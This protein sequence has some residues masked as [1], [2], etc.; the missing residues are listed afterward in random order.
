M[1]KIPPGNRSGGPGNVHWGPGNIT[2]ISINAE[3]PNIQLQI[4]LNPLNLLSLVYVHIFYHDG[5]EP[6][7]ENNVFKDGIGV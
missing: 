1:A 6:N 7:K 4:Q 2:R 3:Q 5:S